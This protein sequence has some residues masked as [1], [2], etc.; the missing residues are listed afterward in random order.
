[1]RTI[2]NFVILFTFAAIV[3]GGIHLFAAEA[4][5]AKAEAKPA[6][7]APAADKA[8]KGTPAPA[9]GQSAAPVSAKEELT[10]DWMAEIIKG[11]MTSLALVLLSAAAVGFAA[12]RFFNLRAKHLAPGYYLNFFK[13]KAAAGEWQAIRDEAAHRPSI[14]ATLGAYLAQHR[15]RPHALLAEDL[16][17]IA[18]REFERHRQRSYPLAI[19]ATMAPMLGLLGTMIG[20]IE[21]FQKVAI[22]GDTGDASVLADSIGK[23]LITTAVGLILAI[24]ALGCYHYLKTKI[25][26]AELKVEEAAGTM[27]RAAESRAAGEKNA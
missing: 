2:L 3:V 12:E 10:I 17:D 18:G 14:V 8:A 1:M 23:A 6:A 22:L 16:A 4:A 24:P 19:I 26:L 13:S 21:A 25:A 5:K 15:S 11:G 20:M 7:A 9:G 27:L